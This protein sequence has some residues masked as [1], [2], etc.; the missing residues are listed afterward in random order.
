MITKKQFV[1]IINRLKETDDI[2][3]K[4]NDII[5]ASTDSAITDFMEAGSLMICHEDL[6]VQL[7]EN[8]FNDGDTIGWWLYE[9]NYGREYTEGCITESDGTPIDLSTA[10]KLYDYLL[11]NN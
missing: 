9:L 1:N 5:R 6:V 11:K 7:L 2:K 10:E 8:M 4:V 3:N